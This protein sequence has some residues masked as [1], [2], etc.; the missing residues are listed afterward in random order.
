MLRL[1]AKRNTDLGD[2]RCK[3]VCRLHAMLAELSGGG[4]DKEIY[5]SDVDRFLLDHK[6]ESAV[7]QVRFD[8]VEELLGDIRRLDAQLKVSH[9]RIRDAVRASGTS[10]TEIFGIGPIIAAMLIGY[11]GDVTRFVNR[12]HYASYN[13]TAPVEFSSGGRVVHRVSQRG[14]RN[15]SHAIHMAAVCQLRQPHSDGRAYFDRR[16]AEGKTGR[17]ALRALKRHVSNAVYKK[18]LTDAKRTKR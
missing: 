14:N 3:V 17:E 4:I 2:Q 8:L 11:S 18:L 12:D 9:K 13:G 5:A 7:E 10:L 15:L 16:V 1:L 6:A